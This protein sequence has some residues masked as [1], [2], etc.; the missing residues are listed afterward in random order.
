MFNLI[1][2]AIRN[3]LIH[4][5]AVI[6]NLNDLVDNYD[7]NQYYLKDVDMIDKVVILTE[8]SNS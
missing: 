2:F 7:R 8:F 3:I 6:S 4:E 5:K 1:F